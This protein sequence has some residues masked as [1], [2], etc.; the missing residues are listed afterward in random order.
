MLEVEARFHIRATCKGEEEGRPRVDVRFFIP[1]GL[2][3]LA[4]MATPSSA[5]AANVLR[6]PRYS[7]PRRPLPSPGV[8]IGAGV[9][10]VLEQGVSRWLG[11]KEGEALLGRGG[12]L[13][14]IDEILDNGRV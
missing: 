9:E 13:D 8:R 2:V 11:L 7:C 14:L 4:E 12:K 6:L 5:K 3:R 1:Q 10:A